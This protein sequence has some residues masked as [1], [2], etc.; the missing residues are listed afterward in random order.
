MQTS[1]NFFY[2]GRII[3][4]R[5]P[6]LRRRTLRPSAL[7]A[8]PTSRRG[9]PQGRQ[10]EARTC[11]CT[12]C[13]TLRMCVYILQCAGMQMCMCAVTMEDGVSTFFCCGKPEFSSSCP[14]TKLLL[15][16][17]PA[18]AEESAV[19]VKDI[20]E[21]NR[22][23]LLMGGECPELSLQYSPFS[24]WSISGVVSS[25]CSCMVS[26]VRLLTRASRSS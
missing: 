23:S 10:R 12:N 3:F 6:C 9:A 1:P 13:H 18:K 17:F 16:A 21:K 5:A 11:S 7:T 2:F 20:A 4:V 19:S 8:I 26:C 15:T 22:K 24:L 25:L 14:N